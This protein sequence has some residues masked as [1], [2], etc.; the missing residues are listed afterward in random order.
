MTDLRLASL[1]DLRHPLSVDLYLEKTA[2]KARV[3]LVRILGGLDYWRYGAEELSALAR[4]TGAR[5]LLIPG[6]DKA[7]ERL[8]RL[9]TEPQE[10][11]DAFWRCFLEGGDENAAAALAALIDPDASKP[12]AQAGRAVLLARDIAQ[13]RIPRA[14][15]IIAR[16]MPRAILPVWKRFRT[17]LS[18]VAWTCCGSR[19]VRRG[20]LVG[21]AHSKAKLRRFPAGCRCLT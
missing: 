19:L 4:R 20:R 12:V 14:S 21:A 5:L 6:C 18:I 9:S 13:R 2:A 7:D 15:C 11:L 10:R 8:V 16:W 1:A 3:I 17:R